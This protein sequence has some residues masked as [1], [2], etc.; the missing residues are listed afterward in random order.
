MKAIL[1]KTVGPN[2]RAGDVIKGDYSRVRRLIDSG[3]AT[4]DHSMLGMFG[5]FLTWIS[6]AFLMLFAMSTFWSHEIDGFDHA[7]LSPLWRW[8]ILLLG[9]Y[10]VIKTISQFFSA[11]SPYISYYM[12]FSTTIFGGI[13]IMAG[14]E[15]ATS[16]YQEKRASAT[17]GILLFTTGAIAF[18]IAFISIWNWNSSNNGVFLNDRMSWHHFLV[19]M[20][21]VFVMLFGW[22]IA[23][24]FDK[25]FK[26]RR[27]RFISFLAKK[28]VAIE[29]KTKA[30]S[31]WRAYKATGNADKFMEKNIELLEESLEV[32]R[33]QLKGNKK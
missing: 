16:R 30:L 8:T 7:M 33:S 23:K 28:N 25:D 29:Y 5:C 26:H 11:S 19:W 20:L 9:L 27:K 10:V 3:I 31:H 15:R 12:S 2:F 18:S 32:D 24:F 17:A 13:F 1:N 21:W 14:H 6:W 4:A 22:A